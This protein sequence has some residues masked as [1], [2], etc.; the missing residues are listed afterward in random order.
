MENEDIAY[1]IS[2]PMILV[3]RNGGEMVIENLSGVAGLRFNF[4]SKLDAER[5]RV[6]LKAKIAGSDRLVN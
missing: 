5:D 6:V 1:L 4:E 3:H 2:Y